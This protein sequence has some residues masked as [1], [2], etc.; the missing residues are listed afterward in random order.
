MK[1]SAILIEKFL[2]D[3]CSEAEKQWVKEYIAQHPE[4]L[5][6]Y[7]TEESWHSFQ[8]GEQLPESISGKM[9]TVI[10][11]HTFQKKDSHKRWYAAAAAVILIISGGLLWSILRSSPGEKI[12]A[13]EPAPANI[14][15]AVPL[16]T[17]MNN[18]KKM[19]PLQLSDGSVVELAP[20]SEVKYLAVFTG[21]SRDI[22]LTGQALFRVTANKNQPFTVHAGQ[23][24][25][26]ALGTVFKITAWKQK[27]ITQVQLI[28]GKIVVKHEHA[29]IK[30]VYLAPGQELRYDQ[31]KKMATVNTAAGIKKDKI[32]VRVNETITF[33]NEPLAGVF[34]QLSG[35]YHV[36]IQYTENSLTGMNFTGTF[37]SSKETLK[38]FLATIGTLN[39]LTI[40]QKDDVIYIVQ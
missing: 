40:N 9:M 24:G 2:R 33:N 18:T 28:S 8:T 4:A 38:E 1:H 30:E 23:L 39:N 16:R 13:T 20:R 11:R 7:L 36:K 34:R 6:P 14:T 17:V 12:A 31:Q 26:T 19:M 37:D 32:P 22:Y 27:D 35:K 5:Q 25:T 10:E 29:A 15:A 21:N 3:E